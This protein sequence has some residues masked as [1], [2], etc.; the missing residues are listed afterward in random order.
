LVS[1][2]FCPAA[3]TRGLRVAHASRG[4][5]GVARFEMGDMRL[6]R[7][8]WIAAAQSVLFWRRSPD[9]E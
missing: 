2:K 1:T 6:E 8:V 9:C 4:A 3:P 5:C 7:A